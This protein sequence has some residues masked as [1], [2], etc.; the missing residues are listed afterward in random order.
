L[1][2]S[3]FQRQYEPILFG[4]G[5]GS[6]HY[7]TGARNVGDVWFVDKPIKNDLHPTMK[8]VELVEKAILLSSRRGDLVLDPFSGVGAT[9]IACHKAGRRARLVELDPHYVDITIK[10]WQAYSGGVARLVSS[11]RTFD[12]VAQ[13]RNGFDPNEGAARS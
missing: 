5:T 11:G 6:K 12:E 7:W 8:P 10:R 13:E 3:D 1:G 9:L 4:W 2:H